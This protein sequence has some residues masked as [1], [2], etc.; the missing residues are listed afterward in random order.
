MLRSWLPLFLEAFDN[1][2]SS[3]ST[4]PTCFDLVSVSKIQCIKIILFYDS[5]RDDL[6]LSLLK[7]DGRCFA[8]WSLG[9]IG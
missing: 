6:L 9:G 5:L 1:R 8:V 7:K 2:D 4:S 3:S